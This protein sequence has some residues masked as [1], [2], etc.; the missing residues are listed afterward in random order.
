MIGRMT[1]CRYN[2]VFETDHPF[3]NVT[4]EPWPF[5]FNKNATTHFQYFSLRS[6]VVTESHYLLCQLCYKQ[7]A[8]KRIV[9][10]FSNTSEADLIEY[11]SC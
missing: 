7:Q 1:E 10:F 6:L 8:H 5:I 4:K 11:Q 3:C 2:K 9:I